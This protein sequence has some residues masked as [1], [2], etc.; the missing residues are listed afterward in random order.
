MTI[1]ICVIVGT[2]I[3]PIIKREYDYYSEL[4]ARADFSR[5]IELAPEAPIPL[6]KTNET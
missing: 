5:A 1:I 3:D 6:V 4:Q 2:N